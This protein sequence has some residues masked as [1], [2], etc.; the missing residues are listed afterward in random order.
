MKLPQTYFESAT[1]QR[2]LFLVALNAGTLALALFTAYLLR[3]MDTSGIRRW[4]E[5]F[6]ITAVVIVPVQLFFLTLFKHFSSVLSYYRMPE[7]KRTVQAMTLSLFAIAVIESI[8]ESI[9]RQELP[10]GVLLSNYIFSLLAISGLRIS[11][12]L[13]HDYIGSRREASANPNR[14]WQ[15]VA[16]LGAGDAGAMLAANWLARPGLRHLPV[17]FL[18]DNASKH[19][20]RLHNIPVLG[21]IDQLG[22]AKEKFSIDKVVI[23][24]GNVPIKR[25]REIVSLTK[26]L[27]FRAEIVPSLV[28]MASGQMK[29]IRIRPVEIQDLLGREPAQLDNESINE[30][31]RGKTVLVTGAGGSIGSELCRQ[32]ASR[33]P[34]NLLLV[35][36]CEVQLFQ[37]EQNL[38][39][40]GHGATIHPLLGDITDE[41]RM[42]HILALYAPDVIFHAAAHKHVPLT[43]RQPW[44]AVRNNALGSRLLIDLA[45][46]Y[47]VPR[48]IFISTD[49]AINPTSVMGATKRMA[50][51]YL[52][53]RQTSLTT[54]APDA[55]PTTKLM[56]VRFG[57]VLGSSGSVIPIFRKQIADGGP[58]RVTHPEVT[59]YFM[60]IPEAVG[61]V[62]QCA[63]LGQGGEIFVLNMGKPVRIAKLARQM[64]E[65]S[66]LRPDIDIPI[67]Y[68]G[69]RP[70]EKLFE[71]LQHAN[72]THQPTSNSLITRFICESVPLENISQSLNSLS[73]NIYKDDANTLK[74]S[75]KQIV[76][77]YHPHLIE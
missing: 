48:L 18:D 47:A 28:E 58:V 12:R 43:E 60:T 19:N 25:L 66:G 68:T 13:A 36:R 54:P 4:F 67:E 34:A 38:I 27:G 14:D 42:R 30:L 56:A 22:A 63:V 45:I 24:V 50:E 8:S 29:A 70:G 49:K 61:L 37:I 10:I 52:Q 55:P 41:T 6:L 15:R 76:P 72:E 31:I 77:E 1:W 9:N 35:E 65:L 46:E 16:I 53:A 7:L 64:I 23:A 59:R 33:A 40:L 20:R 3:Y 69:L 73:S 74:L 26:D 62:L 32:I 51:I 71:E 57:N 44:E 39:D 17:V 11:F 5:D 2:T 21:S 75:I